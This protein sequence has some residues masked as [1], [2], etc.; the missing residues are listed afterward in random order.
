MPVVFHSLALTLL[1]QVSED[2][3]PYVVVKQLTHMFN[4]MPC[5]DWIDWIF[6]CMLENEGEAHEDDKQEAKVGFQTIA[7]QL[8]LYLPLLYLLPSYADVIINTI[9]MMNLIANNPSFRSMVVRKN[10][11]TLHR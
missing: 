1:L 2:D 5:Q 10:N 3:A 8:V 7:L 4:I 6:L 9:V 11:P